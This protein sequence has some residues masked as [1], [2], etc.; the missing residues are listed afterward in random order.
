MVHNSYQDGSP[1]VRSNQVWPLTT[2]SI[3]ALICCCHH[4]GTHA[5]HLEFNC[6]QSAKSDS[7]QLL[8][9]VRRG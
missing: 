4:V 9:P 6:P 7:L 1:R 5:V 8:V 3:A 2:D